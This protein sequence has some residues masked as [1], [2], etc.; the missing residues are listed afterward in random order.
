MS[1]FTVSATSV[2]G[3][4]LPFPPDRSWRWL[5]ARLSFGAAVAW[6]LALGCTVA[7]AQAKPSTPPPATPP[8][9]PTGNPSRPSS[10]P[11]QIRLSAVDADL[12][13]AAISTL[14]KSDRLQIVSNI[15]YQSAGPGSE[16]AQDPFTTQV[17]FLLEFPNKFRGEVVY[18]APAKLANQ[19]LTLVSNGQQV[20]LYK[21]SQKQYT[22][23]PYEQFRVLGLNPSLIGTTPVWLLK[24]PPE[25]RQAALADRLT[26]P[27]VYEVFDIRG[28]SITL[29]V[30]PTLVEA[31]PLRRY[32]F[33]AVK[34]AV[35]FGFHIQPST[36]QFRQVFVN[37]VGPRSQQG[38]PLFLEQ[39][40]QQ[41][42][43]PTAPAD[44]FTFVPPPGAQRVELDQFKFL[45]N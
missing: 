25:I 3:L 26:L 14:A 34:G 43:N 5:V 37:L 24:M 32:E 45:P 40:R 20:W 28:A 44:A 22:V 17:T 29:D 19:T 35:Q 42:L 33:T 27:Q 9:R 10:P 31:Q 8:T 23:M 11:S 36:S 13:K 39:I 41:T 4:S 6:G 1:R 7:Q 2:V 18:S 30:Q 15:R 38:L 12:W 21:P 16:G